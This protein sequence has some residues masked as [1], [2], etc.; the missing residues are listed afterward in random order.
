VKAAK[1]NEL[2]DFV[3]NQMILDISKD[4]E[5]IEKILKKMDDLDKKYHK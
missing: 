3:I 4:T 1:W 2:R 5:S